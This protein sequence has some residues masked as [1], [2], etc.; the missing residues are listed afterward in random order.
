MLEENSNKLK[1]DKLEIDI[2]FQ[3]P[4]IPLDD[5]KTIIEENK[6]TKKGILIN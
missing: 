5:I 4:E 6:K 2:N 3:E 1:D